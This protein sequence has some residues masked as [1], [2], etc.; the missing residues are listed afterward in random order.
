MRRLS[1]DRITQYWTHGYDRLFYFY[2][3]LNAQTS[4][5]LQRNL[6]AQNSQIEVGHRGTLKP[7]SLQQFAIVCW[8]V[9]SK[10]QPAVSSR[11]GTV[12][13]ASD[14]DAPAEFKR[15]HPSLEDSTNSFSI[16]PISRASA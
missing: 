4:A 15:V 7:P 2:V 16:R 1:V 5:A 12:T 14:W 13:A 6:F 8:P 10:Q 11:Q 9:T 3:C